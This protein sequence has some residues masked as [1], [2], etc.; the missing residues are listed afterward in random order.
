MM[1][2]S[3]RPLSR[4]SPPDECS[5]R[6]PVRRA[7]ATPRLRMTSTARRVLAP[8]DILADH[9]SKHRSWSFASEPQK[10][11]LEAALASG[12]GRAIR[13]VLNALGVAGSGGLDEA[14]Y[15]VRP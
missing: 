6:P 1:S 12:W 3:E 2:E 15:L 4:R 10:G 9:P 11:G 13:S 14:E 5:S 8:S 7:S